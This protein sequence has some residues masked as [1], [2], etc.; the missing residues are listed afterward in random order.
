MI[1]DQMNAVDDEVSDAHN[2]GFKIESINGVERGKEMV[3]PIDSH[4]HAHTRVCKMFMYNKRLK[5]RSTC[6]WTRS[7]F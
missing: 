7:L 5:K 6:P 4:T 1:V 3:N 2:D